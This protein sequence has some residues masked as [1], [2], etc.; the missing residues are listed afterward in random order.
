M[1]TITS[2]ICFIVRK[3]NLCVC[4]IVES[5][6]ST[7]MKHIQVDWCRELKNT[8]QNI[9][10]S[11]KL[12]HT[13]ICL[14][15]MLLN[16]VAQH[17]IIILLQATKRKTQNCKTLTTYT[18]VHFNMCFFPHKHNYSAT[19][20]YDWLPWFSLTKTQITILDTDSSSVSS[21]QNSSSK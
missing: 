1:L 5:K 7:S 15:S 17:T 6:V 13:C 9:T 10:E 19:Y 11:W 3:I 2:D 21:E 8:L 18:W 4:T 12:T 14:I 20:N 16:L